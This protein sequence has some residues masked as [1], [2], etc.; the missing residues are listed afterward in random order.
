[1]NRRAICGIVAG[2]SALVA[3]LLVSPQPLLPGPGAASAPGAGGPGVYVADT[4]RTVKLLPQNGTP[5]T[6]PRSAPTVRPGRVDVYVR[7]L[8][9]DPMGSYGVYRFGDDDELPSCKEMVRDGLLCL[10]PTSGLGPGRYVIV[11]RRDDASGC[12]DRFLLEVSSP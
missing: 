8:R 12:A 7:A 9:F 6:F 2:V 11:V 1:M 3:T 10:S 5:A 4:A